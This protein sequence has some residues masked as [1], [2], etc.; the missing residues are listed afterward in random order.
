M[1]ACSFVSRWSHFKMLIAMFRLLLLLVFIRQWDHWLI[2]CRS[3]T[4]ARWFVAISA[5]RPSL[6]FLRDVVIV[7]LLCSTDVIRMKSYVDGLLNPTSVPVGKINKL[8]QCISWQFCSRQFCSRCLDWGDKSPV[9]KEGSV[10][11]LFRQ[12]W[13]HASS[14]WDWH[15]TT[16]IG[17][18]Y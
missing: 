4:V 11:I 10:F 6:L 14:L 16:L 18:I 3:Y 5:F 2:T 1:N 15:F 9:F 7:R 13:N 17:V 8:S 12:Q